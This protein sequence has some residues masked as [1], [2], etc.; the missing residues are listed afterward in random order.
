ME[1]V[2][3]TYSV[4]YVICTIRYAVTLYVLVYVHM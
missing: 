2:E 3:I 4:L 1:P